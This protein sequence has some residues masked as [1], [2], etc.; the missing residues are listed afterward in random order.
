MAVRFLTVANVRRIHA[1]Q[2]RLYGGGYGVLNEPLLESAVA[3]PQASFGGTFLNDGLHAMAAAYLFHLASNH[4]FVDGNKRVATATATAFLDLNGAVLEADLSS[5][6]HWFLP[7]R[8]VRL[9]K[10]P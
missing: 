1:N 7:S 4:A 3:A 9:P 2:I 8:A 5:M 6:E 10:K